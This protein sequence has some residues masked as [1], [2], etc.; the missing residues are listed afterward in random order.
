M[1]SNAASLPETLTP[2]V[3]RKR[4]IHPE[5][6]VAVRRKRLPTEQATSLSAFFAVLSDATRLQVLYALLDASTGELCV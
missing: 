1:G 5:H 6:A 2:D 4:C 3:C